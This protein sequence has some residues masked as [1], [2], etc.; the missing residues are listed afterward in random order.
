MVP[1]F[2]PVF[3][4]W[5]SVFWG[6]PVLGPMFFPRGPFFCPHFS[7]SFVSR[8]P[9]DDMFCFPLGPCIRVGSPSP[10]P[11]MSSPEFIDSFFFFFNSRASTSAKGLCLFVCPPFCLTPPA[12]PRF[13]RTFTCSLS[14]WR[15]GGSRFWPTPICQTTLKKPI[16][17]PSFPPCFPPFL[18]RSYGFS[19][20]GLSS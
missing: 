17:F 6:R 14:C 5:M 13:W 19:P 11:D 3:V 1:C 18:R 7:P 2:L 10:S 20:L 8:G 4:L 16:S 9:C 12:M 15:P